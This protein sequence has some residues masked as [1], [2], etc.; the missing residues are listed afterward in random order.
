LE[1]RNLEFK[2]ILGYIHYCD[3]ISNNKNLVPSEM[4][5]KEAKATKVI[6]PQLLPEV[7]AQFPG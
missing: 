7:H 1:Q 2:A 3:P 4:Q 5:T 6:A